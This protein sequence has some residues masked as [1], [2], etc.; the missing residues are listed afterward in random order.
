M[1]SPN[2]MF[3]WLIP[4]VALLFACSIMPQVTAGAPAAGSTPGATVAATSAVI[5]KDDFSDLSNNWSSLTDAMGTTDYSDGKYL[6]S[7]ADTQSYL[8][9]TPEA[10]GDT[11]DVRVEVDVLKSVDT[12]HDMGILCRFQDS[13]NFYYFL[14]ASDGYFAIGKF[15]DGEEQ[16]IGSDEMKADDSGVIHNG[17][18]DNHLRADC[19]GDTLVLYA[20]GTKLFQVQDS[21]FTKGNVGL[22]AGSYDDTPISVFFDNFVVTKP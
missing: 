16:L 22:I 8:F 12:P 4:A 18:A 6:I 1:K 17:A 5:F 19:V 15:K 10:L 11:T 9:S 20:N 13:D 2:R 3:A 14:V 21:D 7:V